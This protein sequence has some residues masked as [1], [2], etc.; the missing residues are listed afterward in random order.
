MKVELIPAI[1]I[2]RTAVDWERV[3]Q[4]PIGDFQRNPA[5]WDD[6]QRRVLEVAGL[7]DYSRVIKGSPFLHLN[8]WSLPDL[9]KLIKA[10]LLIED[11][12]VPVNESCALF[13]G[14]VLFVDDVPVLVPQCCSTI[15]DFYGWKQIV[16][17]S[18]GSGYFCLEGHPVP[19]AERQG[20]LLT[21]NC[22][23]KDET[24]DQPAQKQIIVGVN[25]LAAAIEKA[26]LVI[27]NFSDK[28]DA[29]STEF[30]V[31]KLSDYLILAKE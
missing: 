28:I 11:E 19:R 7:A 12:P 25:E 2:S 8:Q 23:D 10:H 27:L 26:E 31:Q 5:E 17:P 1:E 21:I 15:A 13:G 14:G 6:Y 29:L 24:F 18:F 4:H 3:G 30:G 16:A 9:R 20:N 22:Q